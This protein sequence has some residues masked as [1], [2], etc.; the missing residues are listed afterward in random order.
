MKAVILA[1][2][3]GTRLKPLTDTMPKCLTEV[4]GKPILI[5][6]LENLE[7][8]RI[9]E[10]IIVVGYLADK[11]RERV[12][13]EFK[14]MKVSY[15]EN[16]IY[17]KTNTSYSLW[18]ALKN[19]ENYDSI[20]ILEGDVF[21]ERKLLAEFLN[22]NFSTS[23]V[24]EK[25]NP[26]LDGSF[27]E[28]K[29][30]EVN[31]WVHKS[32]RYANFI[33]EDKFKTV[34]IHK[35]DRNFAE[36]ILKPALSRHVSE[37]NGTE[38]IEYILQDIV[39]EKGAKITAFETGKLRWFEIDDLNDLRIAEKIFKKK[40]SLD[41]IKSLHGGYWRYDIL[42]F[43]YLVNCH[44]PT[45][46]LIDK[47]KDKLP[48]LIEHYPSAQRVIASYLSKW[49][50]L[51]YFNAEN[52]IVT[53]GSSEAIRALSPMITKILVPI[54]TFNEYTTF[55]KEK[56][57]YFTLPEEQNFRLDADKFI[58][59]TKESGC[60]FAVIVNP[61]NPVGN[62]ASREDIIKILDTGIKLIVDEAFI[63][64]CNDSVE[65]LTEKYEN[66]IIIK[67]LTKTMGLAGLRLGYVLTKNN[68][69]KSE[70]RKI[71]PIWNIN[72]I[73]EYFI[74]E[75]PNHEKEY[76]NSI[77]E[78][79]KERDILFSKLQEIPFLD[80]RPTKSNF[81]FCKTNI[82][83]KKLAEYLYDTHNIILRSALNQEFMKSDNYVR[84][85]VRNRED[86]D[87]LILALKNAE[88][89]IF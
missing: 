18:L 48:L 83:S 45:K 28:L 29:G 38:P 14:R 70:L 65:D 22:L 8:S 2:G 56:V 86:N 11:I 89:V 34:N 85:A 31:D 30:N 17:S 62:T 39:K 76:W 51:P 55:P 54:P 46:E 50:K 63:D 74:E 5:N 81:I 43:H 44:F 82:S 23:T 13:S 78:T 80:P 36:N 61:N 25:Y 47:I 10:A 19:L 41:E 9:D 66:L 27:V 84:I 68:E 3:M 26:S 1:A 53:N 59:Q 6:M 12:G 16:D 64:F 88:A 33:I 35:F 71:L 20:L 4:N 37:S 57:V 49:K 58:K 42:D 73:A 15:V 87:K 7:D 40:I 60:D 69:I 32:R 24:V 72:S 75:F 79:K 21:F 52:L 67:T 77:E